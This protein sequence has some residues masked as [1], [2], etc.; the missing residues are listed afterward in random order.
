MSVG[1]SGTPNNGTPW[2]PYYSHTT[3]IRIPKD[4]GMVCGNSI[5]VPLTIRGS[6]VLGSPG[7]ITLE[8]VKTLCR[9][10]SLDQHRT[11]PGRGDSG[12]GN[13]HF[14]VRYAS[15]R[16]D[17]SQLTLEVFTE[18]RVK[19]WHECLMSTVIVM[20]PWI[21]ETAVNGHKC[22]SSIVLAEP[23]CQIIGISSYK[24][25]ST[26]K[27]NQIKR[28]VRCLY[29]LKSTDWSRTGVAPSFS[30][31]VMVGSFIVDALRFLGSLE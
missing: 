2:A 11:T 21:L 18:F 1:F 15:F 5:R 26:Y 28:C 24:M 4:M 20:H 7:Y 16:G 27:L 6:H 14:Q 22:L 3:P 29:S 12:F 19:T 13:P 23:Y 31:P 25:T 9:I 10:G 30:L 17:D 8:D